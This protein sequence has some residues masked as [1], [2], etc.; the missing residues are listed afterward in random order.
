MMRV[1]TFLVVLGFAA[2]A[3]GAAL[4]ITF[5]PDADPY[6]EYNPGAKFVTLEESDYAYVNVWAFLEET[7][8]LI[9]WLVPIG[10]SPTP[11]DDWTW[12]SVHEGLYN[13]Y[14]YS[15]TPTG[16]ERLD[17]TPTAGD[18]LD[19]WIFNQVA[20]D[21][22][23][24][25]PHGDVGGSWFLLFTLDIHCTG[26]ESVHDIFVDTGNPSGIFLTGYGGADLTLTGT[27][28]PVTVEQVPEPASL[29]LLALGGLAL[30]RRR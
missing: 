2:T 29:A 13:Y 17:P 26:T 27:G 23:L 6:N 10:V 1:L 11:V 20:Y 12:D 9:G 25:Y 18:T 30:I 28:T 5:C 24:G 4:D 15:K 3:Y 19:G 7:E 16:F 22:A 8:T 21:T 14:P